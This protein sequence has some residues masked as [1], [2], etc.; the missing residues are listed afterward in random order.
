MSFSASLSL[1]VS[2]GALT[3]AP[4]PE[5]GDYQQTLTQLE[6][7]LEDFAPADRRA[8]IEALER[9]LDLA[10]RYPGETSRDHRVAEPILHGWIVLA[11]LCLVEG[12]EAGARAAMDTAIRTARDQSL[13]VRTYGPK[14][15]ELY[16]QRVAALRG[17]GTATI[18]VDCELGCE[19]VIEGRRL[20]AASEELL[21]GTYGVWVKAIEGEAAWAYREVELTG[22]GG[23]ETIRYAD[24][25][26]A[27]QVVP[28]PVAPAIPEPR[29]PKRTLPRAAELTGVALGV[30]LM[31]AGAV[32]LSLDG[33][34]DQTKQHPTEGT[35]ARECGSIYHTTT[36]GYS[37]LG[38]GG[39]V[40]VVS[41]VL[42]SVDEVRV[43]RERG[44]Q[45]MVGVSLSF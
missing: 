30:G 23:V 38:V 34:C 42:L 1:F 3:L 37:L 19:V 24:P 7:A 40:L 43:G 45:V 13:P 31:V 36:S 12:D 4:A 21:L 2:L 39:G 33:K 17:A 29:K 22:A 27:T 28:E 18:V 35:T 20:P 44:R 5:G 6:A 10:A 15:Y 11:G 32:L 26:P 16:E 14:V 8:S 9:L 41:G 25:A